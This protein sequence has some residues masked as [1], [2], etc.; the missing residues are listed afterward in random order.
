MKGREPL[1]LK[2]GMDD[3]E[4]FQQFN[5]RSPY[6]RHI[7]ARLA[8]HVVDALGEYP[9][10]IVDILARTGYAT[11]AFGVRE[12]VLVEHRPAFA[13]YLMGTEFASDERG[14]I[15]IDRCDVTCNEPLSDLESCER[16]VI[17][18][19]QA[20]MLHPVYQSFIW[21]VCEATDTEVF[22]MT[23]GPSHHRFTTYRV[24]DHR[25]GVVKDG[26]VMS[27]LSHPIR[28]AT[29]A[30]IV[31]LA[32]ERH[33]FDRDD[34]WPPVA[35]A[36]DPCEVRNANEQAGFNGLQIIEETFVVPGH[37][38]HLYDQNGWTF[39]MRWSP[40]SD[41]SG[42]AKI[43]LLSEAITNVRARPEYDAWCEIE[44]YHPVA[45]YIA[46]CD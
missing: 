27:E 20:A 16:V 35:K 29:H 11:R 9:D 24:A 37:Q 38:I 10:S 30:E 13:E 36:F 15:R 21:Q 17:C 26:E 32:K 5:A 46:T 41:L 45:F 44:A 7:A 25:S 34:A 18:C 4:L 39:Y 22:A 14:D 43:A 6:Y 2:P 33:G 3:L 31:R 8:M 19:E 28:Q 23:L 40:L 1:Y 12:V 42:D